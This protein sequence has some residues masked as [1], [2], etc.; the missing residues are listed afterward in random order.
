VA[1]LV[2]EA[3]ARSPAIAA[4]RAQVASR[5]QMEGPAGALADPMV[6]AML[7]NAGLSPSVGQEEMSMVGAEVR[8][9]IP[10]PGKRAAARAVAAAETA[11][12][13]AALAALERQVAAE[14]Q[15]LYA[16]V[17]TVDREREALAAA[18]QLVDLLAE[19]A[20]ARYGA[21]EA[22]QEAVLKARLQ[23]LRLDER[24]GDLS[25]EREAV[26]GELDRW[27]D[28]PGGTGLGTVTALPQPRPAP[29]AA[30]ELAARGSAEVA[31]A[32]AAVATAERRVEVARLEL[33]PGF[34]A[35]AGIGYRG[36][37]D[38]V[39]TAR[40]GVEVPFWRRQKQ[41]PMLRAAEQELEMARHQLADAEAAARAEGARVAA[42]WRNADEQAL[43][44]R[45]GILP[46]TDAALDAARASYLAGRGDFG[47]VIE[48]FGLWLEARVSLARRE[49]DR[50]A[51]TAAF[52]RLT[53]PAG[54]PRSNP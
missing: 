37:M 50:F 48:D 32:A 34:S 11:G 23:A 51:A 36:G 8:Q 31:S 2:A 17:Y 16:R 18:R 14:V 26:V 52:E 49:S 5:R 25:A 46:Q 42:D 33:K 24:L 20:L 10:Y 30:A 19:T 54:A 41:L 43:R 13:E 22:E 47:T 27:L 53:G 38:P 44:Y 15:S 40:F 35:G 4:A 7:Q 28:R 29:E 12:A 45:E 9:G 3:L 39:V 1:E 21:G 6:E